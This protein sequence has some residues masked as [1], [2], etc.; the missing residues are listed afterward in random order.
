MQVVQEY[1][2]AID[3]SASRGNQLLAYL[4]PTTN[5]R[6]KFR[7]LFTGI[8]ACLQMSSTFA[9]YMQHHCCSELTSTE[10]VSKIQ[11]SYDV[12]QTLNLEPRLVVLIID[13]LVLLV[14][15]CLFWVQHDV[16]IWN[17]KSKFSFL[18]SRIADFHREY[19]R[20]AL[21]HGLAALGFV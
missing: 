12:H 7:L 14:S 16:G 19:V 11:C 3:Q 2:Q 10:Q 1:T 18:I 4:E 17:R 13:T 9:S 15:P 6:Y 21:L 8:C 20:K 5:C